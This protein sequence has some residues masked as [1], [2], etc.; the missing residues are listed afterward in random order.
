MIAA[1][2][3]TSCV[4]KILPFRPERL[5]IDKYQK[6]VCNMYDKKNYIM[7][8]KALKMALDYRLILEKVQGEI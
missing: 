2:K 5:K 4:H 8:N 6:F 7:H 3:D 1:T